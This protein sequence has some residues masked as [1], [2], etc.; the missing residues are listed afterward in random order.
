MNPAMNDIRIN[1][2]ANEFKRIA[3]EINQ[4]NYDNFVKIG[5]LNNPKAYDTLQENLNKHIYTKMPT[6]Y[7]KCPRGCSIDK[8]LK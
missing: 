6:N 2:S 4:Y 5:G 1:L 8:G 3:K 7:A